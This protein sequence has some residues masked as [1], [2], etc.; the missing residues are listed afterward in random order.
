MTK[1]KIFGFPE[2]FF[3]EIEDTS[4]TLLSRNKIRSTSQRIRSSTFKIDWRL[5]TLPRI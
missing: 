1:A 3:K 5:D 2:S 4:T